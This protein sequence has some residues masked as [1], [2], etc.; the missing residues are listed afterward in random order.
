[1]TATST[2]LSRPIVHKPPPLSL[3]DVNDAICLL[4]SRCAP[5]EMNVVSEGANVCIV[6]PQAVKEMKTFFNVGHRTPNNYLEARAKLFGH[7]YRDSTGKLLF[8]VTKCMYIYCPVR[9]HTFVQT[10]IDGA[11]DA[12]EYYLKREL[13][14]FNKYERER[15]HDVNDFEYNPF[16]QSAGVSQIIGGIH[17][18]PGFGAFNSDIDHAENES[19]VNCPQ[20]YMVVDPINVEYDAIC[21]VGG[22][23]CGIILLENIPK[24]KQEENKLSTFINSG[25]ELLNSKGVDGNWRI[26]YDKNNVCSIK[27]SAKI[28]M[29]K[30]GG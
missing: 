6:L 2:K 3:M 17:S 9:E 23:K 1:M 14:F 27:L 11:P 30:A 26:T 4:K 24:P 19:T 7:K 12:M 20:L 18:H 22:E 28:D 15:N 29:E 21:G 5:F 13:G 25:V 8:I 16:I 10:T